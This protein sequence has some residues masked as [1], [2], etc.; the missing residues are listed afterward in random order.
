[1]GAV[2]RETLDSGLQ[3]SV[4]A[5]S[6]AGVLVGVVLAAVAPGASVSGVVVSGVVD[7]GGVVLGDRSLLALGYAEADRNEFE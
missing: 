6:E 2:V 4:G 1:M 5:V 7:F 3:V